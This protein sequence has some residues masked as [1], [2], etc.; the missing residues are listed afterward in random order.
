MNIGLKRLEKL[1]THLEKGKLGHKTFDFS[2]FNGGF[3]PDQPLNTC[4]TAGC[5]IGECPIIFKKQWFFDDEGIPNVYGCSNS[6]SSAK[7]FFKLGY[8]EYIT[9]FTPESESDDYSFN[10]VKRL[11]K[12]ATPKQVA[13]NIRRF[14]KYKKSL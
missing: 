8:F 2:Q 10:K 5:A 6:F 13:A 4:G 3:E 9:L 14:I 7:E 12:K 11:T 1:A